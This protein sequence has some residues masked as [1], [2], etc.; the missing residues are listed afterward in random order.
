MASPDSAATTRA[1][2][3]LIL[4]AHRVSRILRRFAETRFDQFGLSMPKHRAL[5]VI[6][7]RP[8]R[9]SELADTMM[10]SKQ[11]VSQTVD[12]LV[13]AGL[14]TRAED[15]LDRRHTVVTATPTGLRRLESLEAALAEY[16][17]GVLSGL[18]PEAQADLLAA[19]EEL[20][21]LLV[22]RRAEGYFDRLRRV[23]KNARG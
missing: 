10:L 1:A 8:R 3:E 5:R 15:P 22:R 16:L 2:Q 20:N 23:R 11:T 9:M 14:A 19:L 13:K 6:R 4:L 7:R 12:D 18:T 21:A 17:A